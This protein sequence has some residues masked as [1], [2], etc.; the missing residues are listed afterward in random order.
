MGAVDL[1]DAMAQ[2]YALA[3]DA[4]LPRRAELAARRPVAG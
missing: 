4:F 3:P 2:L 1:D